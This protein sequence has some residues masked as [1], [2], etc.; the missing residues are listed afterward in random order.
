MPTPNVVAKVLLADPAANRWVDQL[1]AVLNPILRNVA[2]DLVGPVAA[3]EVRGWY[4][5]PLGSA[6]ASPAVDQVPKWNGSAWVPGTAGTAGAITAINVTGPLSSTGGTTPTLSIVGTPA[7]G[8]AYATG[9]T[10]GYTAA[11]TSGLPLLSGGAGAPSFGALAIGAAGTV[12]GTLPA[13]NGGTGQSTYAVGDLLVASGTSALARLPIGANGTFLG[14]NGTTAAWSV[15]SA[16]TSGAGVGAY[17]A[18]TTTP[19][20]IAL[21]DYTVDVTTSSAFVLNLPT[22]GASAGQAA[23][24]RV[25]VVKNTGGAVVTV[26]PAGVQLIDGAST[27]VV[28]T[29]YASFTFQ[30]TGSGWVLL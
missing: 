19:D 12:S 29:Q 5:L 10:L 17:R 27:F 4:G 6:M 24:G 18:T 8:V 9:T 2:G 16:S 3:P 25:F 11:G 14:S 23:A 13:G 30:S 21:T 22:A 26:T 28:Q 1:L 15:P 7:G 20:T